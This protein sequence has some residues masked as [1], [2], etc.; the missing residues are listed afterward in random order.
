MVLTLLLA[1]A[2]AG[3]FADD[4]L[5]LTLA[6]AHSMALTAIPGCF[7]MEGVYRQDYSLGLLGGQRESASV[8]GVLR[9]GVWERRELSQTDAPERWFAAHNLAQ[10]AFGVDPGAEGSIGWGRYLLDALPGSVSAQYAERRG[11]EWALVQTL[12]GG[13]RA[14]NTMT[15]LFDAATLRPRAIQA[16]V[17]SPIRGL[18]DGGHKVRIIRL[19]M[20]LAFGPD[21]APVSEDVDAKFGQG[22]VTGTTKVHADWRSTACPS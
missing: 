13:P 2:A 22:I 6:N 11:D 21:G 10:S 9:D 16:R 14:D 7:Q 8:R 3:E 18:E 19:N 4:D 1:S 17:A 15:T 5:L 12:A 20:D